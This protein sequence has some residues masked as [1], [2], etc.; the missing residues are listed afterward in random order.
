MPIYV[1]KIGV[2]WLCRIVTAVGY[3]NTLFQGT[4]VFM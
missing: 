2:R 1:T 4:K 3:E